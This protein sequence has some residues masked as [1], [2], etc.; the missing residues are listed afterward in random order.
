M[1]EATEPASKRLGAAG[2]RAP[3]LTLGRLYLEVKA[4]MS[5]GFSGRGEIAGGFLDLLLGITGTAPF[6][7]ILLR[8]GSV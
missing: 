5:A 2:R 1:F 3:A 6:G 7:A 4:R 8:R